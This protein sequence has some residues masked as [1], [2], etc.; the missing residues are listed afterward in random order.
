MRGKDFI[1]RGLALCALLLMGVHG[2][3]AQYH[4]ATDKRV[5]HYLTFSLAGGETTQF[6]PLTDDAIAIKTMP[7]ADAIF[8][9][10]YEL[11]KGNFLMGLGAQVDYDYAWQKVD[12]FAQ[13]FDRKDFQFEEI[14]YAYRY[15]DY[16]DRQHNLQVS[17]P[18]YMGA[19][20]GHNF[21]V[22]AGAKVSLAF[23][24]QHST[25]TYLSTAGTYKRFIHTIENAPTYGYYYTDLYKYKA[26]WDAP[27][28]KITPMAE[29]GYRI[30]TESNSGRIGMRIGAYVEYGIP[31][32]LSRNLDI[33]DYS[34][35]DD[36]PF[37]QNK[38]N[39]TENIVFNPIVNTTFLAKP[40]SQLTVG[41]RWTLQINVTS[42]EHVCMCDGGL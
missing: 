25:T 34:R 33:V 38:E 18:L 21:Y 9:L 32:S 37:T 36:N 20:I 7:G 27:Q 16:R 22:L 15:S 42:P 13:V 24:T 31:L 14:W 11:R 6:L 19:N 5:N 8:Q 2:V 35:V 40:F 17:V 28:L 23:V 41:V 39:L 12:S 10:T 1:L 29:L 30:P 4:K 3:F 26:G